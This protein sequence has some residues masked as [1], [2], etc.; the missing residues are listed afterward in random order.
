MPRFWQRLRFWQRKSRSAPTRA[1]LE[2]L[3]DGAYGS[4]QERDKLKLLI[5]IVLLEGGGLEQHQVIELAGRRNLSVAK[6][7]RFLSGDVEFGFRWDVLEAL[8]LEVGAH[9]VA[10]ELAKDLFAE[11]P[12]RDYPEHRVSHA[13]DEPPL[14]AVPREAPPGHTGG[15][16]RDLVDATVG[17]TR[18]HD[19]EG[20]DG[21]TLR[22]DPR[23]AQTPEQFIAAMFQYRL[24]KGERSFRQMAA[25]V[26][27]YAHTTFAGLRTRTTLPKL[28]L[29]LAFI[30]GSG[31]QPDELKE[32]EE[33]WQRIA[34]AQAA[35]GEEP[36]ASQDPQD[37]GPADT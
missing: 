10:V 19:G 32:W 36:P 34:L 37:P 9:P 5:L 27:Q 24:F 29:A 3:L 2:H 8:L 11:F 33:A 16:A 28:K 17:V 15:D 20:G 1:N 12:R 31:A 13:P 22:P 26:D 18:Q 35:Q 23:N 4:G 6:V 21:R 14:A 25:A 7:Q 30:T